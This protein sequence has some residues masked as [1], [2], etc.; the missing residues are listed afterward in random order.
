[1]MV[2]PGMISR[3]LFKDTVG[4]ADPETCMKVC[5]S[6]NGCSNLAYPTLIMEI[7]PT[8]YIDRGLNSWLFF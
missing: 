6:K 5:G 3:A 8:G 1:M 7:M 4:C 2:L